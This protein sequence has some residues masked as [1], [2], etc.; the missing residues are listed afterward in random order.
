MGTAGA[1]WLSVYRWN[2]RVV[3]QALLINQGN[4]TGISIYNGSN[5]EVILYS[6][7]GNPVSQTISVGGNNHQ[8]S[9]PYYFI[10]TY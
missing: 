5:Y 2:L 3:C 1:Q 8:V 10:Q 9:F 6:T 4:C 7:D